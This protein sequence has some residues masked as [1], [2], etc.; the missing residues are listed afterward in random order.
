MDGVK[1]SLGDVPDIVVVVVVTTSTGRSFGVTPALPSNHG[2]P[3]SANQPI[4][5][6][7]TMSVRGNNSSVKLK[8][9]K[10]GGAL[11]YMAMMKVV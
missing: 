2:T 1:E 3:N 11:G 5:A 10:K 8:Y 7:G 4:V 6:D 9:F